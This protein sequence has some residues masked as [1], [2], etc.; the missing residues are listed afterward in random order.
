M[1]IEAG[2]DGMVSSAHEA[3]VLRAQ[4][5]DALLVTP[6]IR[7]SS[8]DVGD[9]KRVATPSYAVDQGATHLVIGRPIVQA[10]DPAHAFACMREELQGV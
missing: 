10:N 2:I 4:F 3:Q 9:Q 6:G 5:P 7:M 8:G 1:A